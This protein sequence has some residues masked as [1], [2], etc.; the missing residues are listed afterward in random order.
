M[1]NELELEAFE[2]RLRSAMQSVVILLNEAESKGVAIKLTQGR[3][4]DTRYSNSLSAEFIIK[5]PEIREYV[6]QIQ[7]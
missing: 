1:L 2:V 6:K 5:R 4:Q 7:I 3:T